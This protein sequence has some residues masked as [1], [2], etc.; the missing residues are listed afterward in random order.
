MTDAFASQRA[1]MASIL[2]FFVIGALLL[3]RVNDKD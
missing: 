2:V 3:L 1:G